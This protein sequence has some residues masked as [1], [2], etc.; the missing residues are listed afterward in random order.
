MNSKNDF[1]CVFLLNEAATRQQHAECNYG[2][3]ETPGPQLIGWHWLKQF[4]RNNEFFL[5]S[6]E[7][8]LKFLM[9]KKN[10]LLQF[11]SIY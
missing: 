6:D 8:E 7:Y 11:H 4:A 1:G 9:R 5:Y 2:C 10:N 3:G